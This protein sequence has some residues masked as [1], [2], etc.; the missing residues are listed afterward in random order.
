MAKITY[1]L[2]NKYIKERPG[3]GKKDKQ[4]QLR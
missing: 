4:V 3:N 1:I 2:Q